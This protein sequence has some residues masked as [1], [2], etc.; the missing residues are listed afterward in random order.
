MKASDG[1]QST[2][3]DDQPVKVT[4]ETM[5]V[6]K[7]ASP[8]IVGIGT[9]ID[10]QLS[11]AVSEYYAH[12]NVTL[13]DILPDGLSYVRGSA[14]A[15]P[16]SIR[17]DQPQKGQTTIIWELSAD[18]T[19]P[20]ASGK[21]TFQ[22]VVD[23]KY[24]YGNLANQPIVSGD[25][26]TN[27]VT[28]NSNWEDQITEKRSG[29]A[30][31][32]VSRATVN[33]SLPTFRKQVWNPIT[34]QWSSSAEGFTGDTMRFRL[35]FEAVS[36]IDAKE[37]VVRDFLPRGMS[38]V[39]RSDLYSNSG[40]FA[41]GNGCTAAPTVPTI[42][43]LNG[44]Q[45]LEW[46]LCNVT[47][48]SKWQV[49]ISALIADTPNAQPNWLVAN[50]GKLSGQNSY[51]KAYSLRELATVDYVAP[52]ITLTK[53]ADPNRNLQAGSEINYTLNL[54]NNGRATAYNLIVEDTLPASLLVVNSGGSSSPTGTTYTTLSGNPSTGA[55]GVIRWTTI[56]S[57]GVGKTIQLLYKAKIPAGVVA[58][59]SMTNLASVGYNSRADNN[60]HQENKNS[61][62]SADNT[63][64]ATVYVRG[65]TLSKTA[66]KPLATIGETVRWTLTGSVPTGVIAY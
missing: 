22:A 23:A 9:K 56:P 13:T 1:S 58:G 50:F 63:D 54:T 31:P 49:E 26:F 2:P 36:N 16:S 32:D 66:D 5:T 57:L 65:V 17:T 10:Y 40:T 39:T 15:E 44:L 62:V 61:D 19:L 6:N 4:A 38:F 25:S 21:I 51:A 3:A 35:Q 53:S 48:A 47:K 8:S 7:T 43:N 11:Y 52:K 14:S 41:S 37:I 59:Q 24:E 45:Y 29:T 20:G 28:L 34:N 60:G 64:E 46:K 42:G 33:T 55:G 27:E 12:T 18:E 30:I